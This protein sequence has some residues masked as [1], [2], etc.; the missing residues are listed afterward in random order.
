M[1]K[2]NPYS[3]IGSFFFTILLSLFLKDASKAKGLLKFHDIS[4]YYLFGEVGIHEK[5]I[6]EKYISPLFHYFSNFN[7]S[8]RIDE[9]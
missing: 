4:E 2:F 7:S 1:V 6:G 3:T 5:S 8:D 9:R